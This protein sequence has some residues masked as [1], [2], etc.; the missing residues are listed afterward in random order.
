MHTSIKQIS[1][2][3]GNTVIGAL[4]LSPLMYKTFPRKSEFIHPDDLKRIQFCNTETH[5]NILIM[6][7]ILL[8]LVCTYRAFQCRK[9][10][11]YLNEATSIVFA[12]FI[13]TL[14]FCV[15]F[16]IAYFQKNGVDV[17]VVHLAVLCGNNLIIIVCIYSYKLY[18]IIFHPEQN[19]MQ[20]LRDI[21]L[22]NIKKSI[23]IS[24]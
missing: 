15:M 23:D 6:F 5:F 8:H 4:I 21:R 7:T 17:S 12:S 2:L 1:I 11:G 20:F 14:S 13:P 3:I 18:I 24:Y 22:E 9:L 10:P 19:T 16:P